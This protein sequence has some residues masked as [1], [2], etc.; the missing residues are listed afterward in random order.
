MKNGSE[1]CVP[2]KALSLPG[3][4]EGQSTMPAEGDEV[5]ITGTAKVT[6]IDGDNAYLQPVTINGESIK[7]DDKEQSLDEEEASMRDDAT[8]ADAKPQVY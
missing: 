2:V 8:E 1:I 6:R 5:D 7:A 3:G 4:Q